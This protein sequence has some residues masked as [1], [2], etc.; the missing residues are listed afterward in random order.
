M[1]GRIHP[2][3]VLYAVAAISVALALL[4]TIALQPLL[5]GRALLAPFIVAVTI[6]ALYGGVGPALFATALSVAANLVF[7]LPPLHRFSVN[8]DGEILMALFVVSGVLI[9]VVAIQR[10]KAERA[11][12]DSE[13]RYR[14]LVEG[15]G[16]YA[17]FLLDPNGRVASWNAGAEGLMG[18]SET[19]ILGRSFAS[20][21]TP[22]DATSGRPEEELALAARS[23]R[24]R[25]EGWRVR[26]DGSR[27]YAQGVVRAVRDKRQLRAY[28]KIMH[29]VTPR[30]RAEQRLILQYTVGRVL[31]ESHSAEHGIVRVLEAICATL[32]W[33]YGALWEVDQRLR[34]LRCGVIWHLGAADFSRFTAMCRGLSFEPGVGLPGRAWAD[35]EPVWVSDISQDSNFPRAA[36]AIAEGLRS[37]FAVP[38][39]IGTETLGTFE[40]FK[41]E[42]SAPDAD[43][44]MLVHALGNHV[45]QF[46]ERTRAQ[47]AV[48]EG[49][50]RTRAIV[51]TA[52]DG[53][54]TMDGEGTIESVNPAAE[55][56]FG[57]PGTT[58]IGQNITML[59]PRSFR[60]G[61]ERYRAT[62]AEMGHDG[63]TGIGRE[64]LGMRKD[65]SVF[66]IDVSISEV[67]L[68]DRRIFTGIVR[69]ISERKRAEEERAAALQRERQA[70]REA[71]EASRA[72]DEFLAV[73]SHEL[74]TPLTPILT[75]SRLLR[76]GKL[77]AAAT[78]R[79][80]AAVER[81]ARSQAQLI[82]DLLD[83]SRVTSGKLRLDVRQ[84][85]LPPVVEAAVESIRPA[86][87]AK[88]IR[89]ALVLDRNAG[90]VSGDA[91][92]LQQV[93]WNLLSN[94]IKFTPRG[95]QVQVRLQAINA[96]V[97]LAVSDTGQGI[98]PD[99]LPHVFERF[100]QADSSSTRAHGGLG[101]GLAI[102]RHLVELHGGYV[103]VESPGE[104]KGATFI[105]TLPLAVMA[106]LNLSAWSGVTT[107]ERGE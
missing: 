86:A 23:G 64:M 6:N 88:G 65:G 38:L 15:A 17:I 99:F 50:A 87:E 35:N 46:I 40:F 24:A 97:E 90:M 94:A 13:Q 62:A 69:D 26:K 21:F 18:Y 75:W 25:S 20:F 45:G 89:L 5:L 12:Q 4:G 32:G 43:V 33:D 8:I 77:D 56:L 72:K 59:M 28:A 34:R 106:N 37:G 95:G 71:E 9:A 2:R 53:I 96:H 60:A 47:A 85:E 22:A 51:D 92:R 58:M 49:A 63:V 19:E 61:D 91:E 66:P 81:A 107:V 74:R 93:V 76:T 84:I 101:L 52:I 82:E 10:T 103:R 79:A 100:R 105:V 102:V 48:Q 27:F 3:V 104:D 30:Y 36:A 29:D 14:L 41:R 39:R 42:T 16:D 68:N 83:V 11:L 54:I 55:R 78:E 57:Y 67:R 73:I 1:R 7:P 98:A 80:L 44:L 31:A 70:R